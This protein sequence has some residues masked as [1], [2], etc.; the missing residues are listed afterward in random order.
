MRAQIH[1][2]SKKEKM[3][4]FSL[5]IVKSQELTVPGRES[6]HMLKVIIK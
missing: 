5:G 1:T 6:R 2:Y 4:P 3:D